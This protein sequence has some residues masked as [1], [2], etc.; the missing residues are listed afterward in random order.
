[1]TW[2]GKGQEP[3]ESEEHG[4]DADV[5]EDGGADPDEDEFPGEGA[6]E[7][8][9]RGGKMVPGGWFEASITRVNRLETTAVTEEGSKEDPTYSYAY[10]VRFEWA[11]AHA[12]ALAGDPTKKN[13]HTHCGA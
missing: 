8:G 2:T 10:D 12:A 9:G 1:M 13:T 5:G 6:G 4:E 3:D 11:G 7:G